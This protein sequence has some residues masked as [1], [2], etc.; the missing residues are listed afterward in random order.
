MG[1]D[2]ACLS[3]SGN[4]ISMPART[5]SKVH[6]SAIFFVGHQVFGHLRKIDSPS[7]RWRQMLQGINLAPM[8]A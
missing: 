5:I 7:W 1:V 8:A 3:V 4:Q 2:T 6:E